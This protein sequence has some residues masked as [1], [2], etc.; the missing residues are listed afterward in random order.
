MI[1]QNQDNKNY[2]AQKL[3]A[4]NCFAIIMKKNKS[5]DMNNKDHD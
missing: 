3:K 1:Q 2:N 5:H 4:K